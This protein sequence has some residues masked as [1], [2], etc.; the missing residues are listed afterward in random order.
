MVDVD[1]FI[2]VSMNYVDGTIEVLD[3]VDV[4]ETIEPECP[5][6]ILKYDP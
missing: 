5:S 3:S 2:T 1:Y 4:W 6:Q